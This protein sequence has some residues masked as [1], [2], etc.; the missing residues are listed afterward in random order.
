MYESFVDLMPGEW[1]KM[2]IEVKGRRARLFV[3]G[4][5]Q[6]GLSVE[7]LILANATAASP[8]GLNRGRWRVLPNLKSAAKFL[9]GYGRLF[10]R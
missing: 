6:P 5:A 10:R 4:A 3:P 9:G 1:R 2:R 7:D 8:F